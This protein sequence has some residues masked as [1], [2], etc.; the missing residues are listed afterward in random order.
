MLEVAGIFKYSTEEI[1]NTRQFCH[2]QYKAFDN[3]TSCRT[4]LLG[5]HINSCTNAVLKSRPITLAT[6]GIAPN[7]SF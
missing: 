4:S 1:L 6:T 5:G 2:E 7:A 3:I